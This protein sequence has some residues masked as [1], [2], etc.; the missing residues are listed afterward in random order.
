MF[1]G[2]HILRP[3]RTYFGMRFRAATTE[4]VAGARRARRDAEYAAREAL[5]KQVGRRLT[6]AVELAP[7]EHKAYP[8]QL[9]VEAQTGIVL[10]QR[11]E[12]FGT[13]DV[14][15]E[16]VVGDVLDPRC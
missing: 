12:G 8:I 1:E 14:W 2:D 6:R 13:V 3:D 10:E 16:F 4:G 5:S 9:V 15:V 7:P 11:N